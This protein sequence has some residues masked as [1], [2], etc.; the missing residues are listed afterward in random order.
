ME[1]SAVYALASVRGV[2]A[3]SFQ[4][5][6]DQLVGDE[7]TGIRRESFL[8]RCDEAARLLVDLAAAFAD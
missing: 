4:V 1:T 8:D 5:V 6:S 7:W 2:D 3:L